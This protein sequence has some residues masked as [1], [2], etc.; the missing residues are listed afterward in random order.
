MTAVN[1]SKRNVPR[2]G[3]ASDLRY[4]KRANVAPMRNYE[5]VDVDTLWHCQQCKRNPITCVV[6]AGQVVW[7][8]GAKQSRGH[9][10][11]TPKTNNAPTTNTQ[12]THQQSGGGD[13]GGKLEATTT[14]SMCIEVTTTL[15]HIESWNHIIHVPAHT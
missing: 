12:Q 13:G 8:Q 11:T 6:A 10:G 15:K 5:N 9:K 1:V 14:M 4:A 2:L 7:S 3:E